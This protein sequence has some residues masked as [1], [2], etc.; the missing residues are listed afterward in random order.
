IRDA[1]RI[2][3]LLGATIVVAWIANLLRVSALYLAAYW[4]GMDA[5][6]VVHTHLGWIIFVV[7]AW[8]LLLGLSKIEKMEK[9]REKRGRGKRRRVIVYVFLLLRM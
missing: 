4:Y 2:T 8:G 3:A 5:M 9:S 6:M 7:V 1:R